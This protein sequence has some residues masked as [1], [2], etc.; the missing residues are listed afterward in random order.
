MDVIIGD[1]D[2]KLT[3]E[4][5]G[6][7]DCTATWYH[8]GQEVRQGRRHRC[9]FNGRLASLTITEI[10]EENG[11]LYECVLANSTGEVKTSCT[12]TT[13]GQGRAW[14]ALS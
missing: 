10:G 12:L 9:R 13:Q 6:G 1:R 2:I 14:A 4:V 11:G 5:S 3:C 8:N 7:D